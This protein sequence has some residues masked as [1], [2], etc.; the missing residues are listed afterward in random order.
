ME[1]EHKCL[2]VRLSQILLC[3]RHA[4]QLFTGI[5]TPRSKTA[6][7][8]TVLSGDTTGSIC[9]RPSFLPFVECIFF[10]KV[11]S[12]SMA[13]VCTRCEGELKCWTPMVALHNC[14]RLSGFVS[15][16]MRRSR[17]H[18]EVVLLSS[19]RTVSVTNQTNSRWT[20]AFQAADLLTFKVEFL[21]VSFCVSGSPGIFKISLA[22]RNLH[23]K[24]T[25]VTWFLW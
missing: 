6:K 19:G 15:M 25:H 13:S 12:L 9:K 23:Q 17:P 18:G 22:T 24:Y 4:N 3:R 1:L 21:F 2:N 14:R 7:M 11:R 8:R 16:Q 5:R 20:G 10:W